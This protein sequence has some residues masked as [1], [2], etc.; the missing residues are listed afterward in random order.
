M[1]AVDG[2]V[3]RRN[4]EPGTH[5]PDAFS[6]RSEKGQIFFFPSPEDN[7]TIDISKD[8]RPLSKSKEASEN[9]LLRRLYTLLDSAD[10]RAKEKADEEKLPFLG[11]IRQQLDSLQGEKRLNMIELN[12]IRKDVEDYLGAPQPEEKPIATEIVDEFRAQFFKRLKD[13]F[14]RAKEE[15]I[16]QVNESREPEEV[17]LRELTFDPQDLNLLP[18]RQIA[19]LLRLGQRTERELRDVV[20]ARVAALEQERSEKTGPASETITAAT[21]LAIKEKH[22]EDILSQKDRGEKIRFSPIRQADFDNEARKGLN[23]NQKEALRTWIHSANDELRVFIKSF[24]GPDRT[25]KGKRPKRAPQL[26]IDKDDA[27]RRDLN[28]R[29]TPDD[30]QEKYL[31][32]AEAGV[33]PEPLAASLVVSAESASG[34]SSSVPEKTRRRKG[35]DKGI[36]DKKSA[37]AQSVAGAEQS[38]PEKIPDVDESGAEVL[39]RRNKGVLDAMQKDMDALAEPEGGQAVSM[40]PQERQEIEAVPLVPEEKAEALPEPAHAEKEPEKSPAA[41][42]L[43]RQ[44][45]RLTAEANELRALYVKEDIDTKQT[46]KR[47]RSVLRLQSPESTG[48]WRQLYEDKL[49]ELQRVEVAVLQGEM[50]GAGTAL[51][52]TDTRESA[53]R[54]L[55]YYK[56]DERVNLIKERDKYRV[57]RQRGPLEKIEYAM[58]ILGRKYNALSWEKKLVIT[59]ALAGITI[60][61]TLSGGAAAVGAASV[62][63]WARRAASGAG[64]AVGVETLLDSV[65]ERKRTAHGKE[66]TE[67]QLA[68]LGLTKIEPALGDEAHTPFALDTESLNRMLAKDILA[69]DAK[70]QQAKRA[71]TY[72][73]LGALA[74]GAAVGSG[75]LTHIVMEQFG[76][77]AVAETLQTHS[78]ADAHAAAVPPA[79]IAPVEP[80]VVPGIASEL[81]PFQDILNAP[82]PV[83]KGDSVWK[84]LEERASAT[85]L[86]DSQKTYFIDAL[87]DKVGDVSLQ[88]GDTFDFSAHGL[89]AEDIS[90]ALAEAEGLSPEKIASIAAHDSLIAEYA[91]AHPDVKLTDSLVDKIIAGNVDTGAA[92]NI[93]ESAAFPNPEQV[94]SGT[95]VAA[96]AN[97]VSPSV[98]QAVQTAA[99]TEAAAQEFTPELAPRVDSWYEQLFHTEQRIPGQDWS[100]DRM[101]I[102]KIP[103]RDVVNDVKLLAHGEVSGYATGMK[104][105]QLSNFAQFSGAAS[106]ENIL[107]IAEFY[108]DNH[109]ATIG[110]YLKKIAPLVQHGQR[111]GS[112]VAVR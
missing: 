110:D 19:V 61:T 49:L 6:S 39:R 63:V 73:K 51:S 60:A 83:E 106:K 10:A 16:A 94:I 5:P 22:R 67:K 32:R 2:I 12:G 25:K 31:A 70:W 38:V 1:G 71:G 77:T 112:Y 36:G 89:T 97:D 35:K 50:A 79:E 26:P 9:L 107:S 111:I 42:A 86:G 87:K 104:P 53:A 48:E 15:Y 95:D 58:G 44:L 105:E 93:A 28:S 20:L 84:I 78:D 13:S 74:L 72:R 68:D 56:L 82:Y 69:S 100:F 27:A 80:V 33:N 11:G 17:S 43:Y 65:G 45:D 96:T 21:V 41:E 55:D 18:N 75:W 81:K 37:V 88:A 57:E 24:D 52:A 30:E 64:L 108:K 3:S 62:L 91:A 8:E 76:D 7:K 98:D 90:R 23:E 54:L 101:R 102:E 103:L 66:E 85:G 59:G 99:A 4:T 40:V 47:L 109:D 46:W 14:R 92:G 29:D 34:D